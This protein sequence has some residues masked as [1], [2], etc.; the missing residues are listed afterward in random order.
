MYL[1][2]EEAKKAYDKKEIPVGAVIVKNG[3]VVGRGYN[4]KETLKD[5]TQHAEI[6]AIRDATKNLGDWRLNGSTI[7]VTKEPCIMCAGAIIEAR[8]ERVVFGV[9]DKEKGAFGGK[10]NILDILGAK[11]IVEKGVLSSESKKLLL[12]FFKYLRRGG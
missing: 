5:P 8:I 10:F 1:A 2:I 9:I 4:L 6:V 7:Y 11:I 3:E 12:K